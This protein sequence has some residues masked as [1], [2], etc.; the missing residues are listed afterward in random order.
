L[1][2]GAAALCDQ[3]WAERTRLQLR[4]EASALEAVL[5]GAGL[6][7]A[8]GTSLYRLVRH[9]DAGAL[10]EALARQRIW[11]RRFDW[12]DDLLRFGLPP[13]DAARDRLATALGAVGERGAVHLN[14]SVA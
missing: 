6:Q 10:H 12:T 4:S 13:D 1:T 9:P 8:G 7:A 14:D 5:L 11:C 3:A 2:I